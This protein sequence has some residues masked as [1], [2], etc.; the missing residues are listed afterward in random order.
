VLGVAKITHS[1]GIF[2]GRQIKRLFIDSNSKLIFS[3]SK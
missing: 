3:F 1:D 2:G